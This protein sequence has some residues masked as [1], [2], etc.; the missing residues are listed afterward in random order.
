MCCVQVLQEANKLWQ[1]MCD[2]TDHRVKISHD[3]GRSRH[4]S[5][6]LSLILPSAHLLSFLPSLPLSL[7][8]PSSLL[9]RVSEDVSDSKTNQV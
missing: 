5:E 7:S 3:G 6:F 9:F 8:L 4:Q 2:P 1:R